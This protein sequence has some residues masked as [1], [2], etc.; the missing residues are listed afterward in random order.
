MIRQLGSAKHK[1]A[2]QSIE[3]LSGVLDLYHL[4]VGEYPTQSQ[5]LAA[6]N[7]N[8]GNVSGWNGPYLKDS[9]GSAIPGAIPSSTITPA[10]GPSMRS[11]SSRWAPTV[12]RAAKAK[13]PISSIDRAS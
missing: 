5:G 11:T 4:D 6:L 12:S 2:Q 9:S 8:P 7:D 1:I 3:R 10:S 13:T